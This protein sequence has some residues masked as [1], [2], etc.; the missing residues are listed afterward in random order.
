MGEELQLLPH[1]KALR[2]RSLRVHDNEAQSGQAGQRCALNVVGDIQKEQITRGDLLV[3]ALDS[4]ST[5]RF[6]ASF[7]LLSSAPFS[8]KHLSPVKLHLGAR[9]FEASVYFIS[10][11]KASR[12]QPGQEALVQF[13][14]HEPI[15]CGAQNSSRYRG[16][17]RTERRDEHSV[18]CSG[19]S[20][21]RR[22]L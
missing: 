22:L 5:Q 19:K 9:H 2:V 3:A 7:A 15:P 10:A 11:V 18:N 17:R 4:P 14:A 13:M 21:P 1:N 8:L 6:D 12:L 20:L 16:P